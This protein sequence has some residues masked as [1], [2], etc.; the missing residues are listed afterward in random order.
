MGDIKAEGK[1]HQETHHRVIE[2]LRSAIVGTPSFFCENHHMFFQE[3][4]LIKNKNAQ[5]KT[6]NK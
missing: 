1:E 2:K 6:S 3:G 5:I 4:Q